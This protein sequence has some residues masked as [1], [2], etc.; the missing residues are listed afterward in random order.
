MACIF[1]L[2]VTQVEKKQCWLSKIKVISKAAY[3]NVVD[4]AT[5]IQLFFFSYWE[6]D[7]EQN[8]LN[9]NRMETNLYK[10]KSKENSLKVL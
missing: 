6:K 3:L 10:Q 7:T 2:L 4:I 8:L 5:S 1:T 9:L